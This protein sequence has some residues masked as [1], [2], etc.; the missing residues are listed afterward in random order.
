MEPAQRMPAQLEA[1]GASRL[2]SVNPRPVVL[3]SFWE[4]SAAFIINYLILSLIP[5]LIIYKYI[6]DVFLAL[7]ATGNPGALM[8]AAGSFFG[9]VAFV[10]LWQF[11]GMGW[12]TYEDGTDRGSIGKRILRLRVINDRGQSPGF[13]GSCLRYLAMLVSALPANLGFAM[14]L[15]SERLTLHDRITGMRVV[16]DGRER[17]SL[18]KIFGALIVIHVLAYAVPYYYFMGK[19]RQYVEVSQEQYKQ[20]LAERAKLARLKPV[21]APWSLTHYQ[22]AFA[23]APPGAPPAGS[24]KAGPFTISIQEAAGTKLALAFQLPLVRDYPA[25]LKPPEVLL[26]EVVNKERGDLT[27]PSGFWKPVSLQLKGN[28]LEGAHVLTTQGPAETVAS[29]RGSVRWYAPTQLVEIG[30]LKP[31]VGAREGDYALTAIQGEN[32]GIVWP[33]GTA[34]PYAVGYTSAGEKVESH[35]VTGTAPTT[36][37]WVRFPVKPSVIKLYRADTFEHVETHFSVGR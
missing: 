16:Q 8:G 9:V 11:L 7:L 34:A 15:G 27:I 23:S 24:V 29:I 37:Y 18:G 17:P 31:E 25:F 22:G 4:R 10:G 2:R 28:V 5:T 21:E 13:G 19:L 20:Q 32:F 6:G 36:S 26:T 35:F 12:I 1:D 14:A 33:A 30:E 3:A